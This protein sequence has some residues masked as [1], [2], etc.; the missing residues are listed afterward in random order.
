LKPVDTPG[1]RLEKIMKLKEMYNVAKEGQVKQI[2]HTS[3]VVDKNAAIVNYY[4]SSGED[5]HHEGL[6]T[7][8]EINKAKS[9]ISYETQI[10]S[11]LKAIEND[12]SFDGVAALMDLISKISSIGVILKSS[13]VKS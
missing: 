6:D 10:N 1:P 11:I 12:P 9:R 4:N 5:F 8:E 3:Q 13:S 7:D 2:R